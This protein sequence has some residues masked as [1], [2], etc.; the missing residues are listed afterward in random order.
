MI[1]HSALVTALP[2]I[3][4]GAARRAAEWGNLVAGVQSQ[5]FRPSRDPLY[6]VERPPVLWFRWRKRAGDR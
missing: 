5:V 6:L 3:P 2:V 1:R 4:T